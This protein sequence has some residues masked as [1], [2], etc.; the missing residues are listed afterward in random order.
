M[1][2]SSCLNDSLPPFS[3]H[4]LAEYRYGIFKHLREIKIF[5]FC[6]KKEMSVWNYK[7]LK[8]AIF[9][10]LFRRGRIFSS[11]VEFFLLVWQKNVQG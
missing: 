6:K 3:L 4:D 8:L 11:V 9:S 10:F 1:N 2:K 7:Q 5:H